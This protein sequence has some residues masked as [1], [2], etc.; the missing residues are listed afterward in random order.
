M[1]RK[2]EIDVEEVRQRLLDEY[3]DAEI[4]AI[5]N[6]YS[7]AYGDSGL[8]PEAVFLEIVCDAVGKMNA[9]ATE[10]TRSL[11]GEVGVFLRNVRKNVRRQ[12]GGQKKSTTG[13]GGV[14]FSIQFTKDMSWEEQL[15]SNRKGNLKSS[16]SFYLG[17]T[18]DVY[19]AEFSG[20]PLVMN[21][22]DFKKSARDKHNVPNRVFKKLPELLKNPVMTFYQDG[23]KAVVL[24]DI[25]AD[26]KPLVAALHAGEQMDRKTVTAV[27]SVY[28]VDNWNSWISNQAKKETEIQNV[29]R[30]KSML[31]T[32]G[33]N[34]SVEDTIRSTEGIVT[35]QEADVK[36]KYSRE[37]DSEGNTL[38]A[39]Q[40]EFFKDS[41][42]RDDEGNLRVVYHGTD[43][44]FT[45]FDRTKARANMDIQGSFFS[46]WDMD[47]GGYGGNVKAYY[48]NIT[49]P[50]PEGTA[51]RALN[52]Y[53]G[54]N[55]AGVKAREYLE[56][57]GY[58]G[59]NNGDEEYIAFYPEQ[60]KLVS[61]QN[62]SEHPDIRYS[63]EM[64][65]VAALEKQVKLLRKQ[66]EYWK[67][68]SRHSDGKK[69]DSKAVRKLV[70]QPISNKKREPKKRSP[71]FWS[72]WRD[73]NPR[74]HGPEPCA[75]PNFATPR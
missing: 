41:K 36:S 55:G 34:A 49:K 46:P 15:R 65:P 63:R 4:N 37:L 5:I 21:Q 22:S 35:Q 39:G 69:A 44:E 29:N 67:S 2:G 7:Q 42:I 14:K 74:P 12:E 47:A 17:V 59:V 64:D 56:S 60:I 16:D 61:N 48:L 70:L 25:D 62:P 32:Y 24:D 43:Q 66:K 71:Q 23:R 27:T 9:F 54:Q 13:D 57:L 52:R 68:Q 18:P 53:K 30:A 72:E 50:A 28:G 10:S 3:D 20:Y 51:Y 45:V 1:I 38:S 26:G 58:D 31:Q 11:A 73:S 33:S 40:I 8:D 75:I 6:L 19:G